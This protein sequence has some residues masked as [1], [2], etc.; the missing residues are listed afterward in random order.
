MRQEYIEIINVSGGRLIETLDNIIE[1]SR[2]EAGELS[3]AEDVVDTEELLRFLREFFHPRAVLSG[4]AI[5]L[6]EHVRG[7]EARVLTDEQKLHAVLANLIKNA[8]KFTE[9]GSIEVGSRVENDTLLFFVRDTGIGVPENRRHA[10]FDPFVQSDIGLHRRYEGSGLGL[11]IARAYVRVLG[12]DISFESVEGKGSTFTFTIPY[13]QTAADTASSHTGV[14]APDLRP[15]GDRVL[16]IAE[17]D[18]ASTR[19]LETVLKHPQLT[20][21]LARTGEEAITVLREHPEIACILMDLKMPDMDGFEATRRIR[22]FDPT[23][24]IIAQTAY[25]HADDLE[26]ALAAGC[27]EYLTK[28]LSR[29]ALIAA[30]NHA[31]ATA[32]E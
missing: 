21:L 9:Q 6:A 1:I 10:I 24:P 18:A 3:L 19:Y 13:R 31:L 7:E 30:V 20:I 15:G 26:K 14:K 2:I 22:E 8:V 27:N 17:D 25:A 12:G 29:D 5:D 32:A 16:L 4:S 23:L 11:S 28:P